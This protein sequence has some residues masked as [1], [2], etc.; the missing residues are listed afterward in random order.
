MIKTLNYV[1]F[2]FGILA[3]LR[4]KWKLIPS[5]NPHSFCLT[6]LKSFYIVHIIVVAELPANITGREGSAVI[7]TKAQTDRDLTR[8]HIEPYQRIKC[9]FLKSSAS[10]PA[11][12]HGNAQN[13]D[14]PDFASK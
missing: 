12:W 6:L 14:A 5:V 8:S 3:P 9:R 11:V 13:Q 7:P 1:F 10:S 4:K 2:T